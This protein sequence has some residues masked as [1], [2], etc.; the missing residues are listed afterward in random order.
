M[1]GSGRVFRLTWNNGRP[2]SGQSLSKLREQV[3][4]FL[5]GWASSPAGCLEDPEAPSGSVGDHTEAD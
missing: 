2:A 3:R 4:D 5:P 1:G